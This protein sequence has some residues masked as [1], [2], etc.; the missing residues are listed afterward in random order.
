MPAALVPLIL[1]IKVGRLHE[2]LS[3]QAPGPQPRSIRQFDARSARF[4]TIQVEPKDLKATLED[5]RQQDRASPQSAEAGC[6][7]GGAKH[8]LDTALNTRFRQNLR[9]GTMSTSQEV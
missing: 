3:R 2:A 8:K 9:M 7:H 5:D 6:R 1:R 4:R